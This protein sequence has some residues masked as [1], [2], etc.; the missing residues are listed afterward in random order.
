MS[1]YQ[2]YER[3]MRFLDLVNKMTPEQTKRYEELKTIRLTSGCTG[4]IDVLAVMDLG[5]EELDRMLSPEPAWSEFLDA[6]CWT[7]REGALVAA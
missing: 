5:T 2:R 7:I 6:Y 1:D 4:V 3:Q